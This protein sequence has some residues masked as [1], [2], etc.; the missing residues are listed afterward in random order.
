MTVKRVIP[1]EFQLHV[2]DPYIVT[3]HHRDNFPK[4]NERLAPQKMPVGKNNGQD[5]D[6]NADWRMY[7]GA[8]VPGFPVHPHRGFETVTI[9]LEGYAD[10]FDSKGS[11]GRYGEGD[12]Q[13]MTAGEGVQ[14]SE[15]FPLLNSEGDNPME[16]F[17][18]W[19][20]LPAKNKFAEPGY[21]MFWNENIPRVVKESK[22]GAKATVRVLAGEFEGT[23]SLAPLPASWASER[24]NHVEIWVVEMEPESEFTLPAISKSLNRVLYNYGEG[25]VE[26]ADRELSSMYCAELKGDVEAVVKCGKVATKL[27]L[28]E[29]EPIG[30]PVAARGPFVLN[31][32]EELSQAFI[33]YRDTEFGGWSWD[34]NDPIN[35]KSAGRFASY[36]GGERVEYPPKE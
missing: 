9:M 29:G 34:R 30:E 5:F 10:H 26:V 8:D 12:V 14:H 24:E 11:K 17:Q 16:L 3:F 7:H 18:V 35:P 27:L 21:K 20:N 1:M 22:N 28:L 25:D 13:W 23:Q 31:T 6:M 32:F 4:G 36:L 33:D 2:L 15:M 19:L